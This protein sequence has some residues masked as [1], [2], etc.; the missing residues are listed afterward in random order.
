MNKSKQTIAP[1]GLRR[2]NG[3]QADGEAEQQEGRTTDRGPQ[4]RKRGSGGGSPPVGAWGL[5]PQKIIERTRRSA[6]R[7]QGALM[8]EVAGRDLGGRKSRPATW[9]QEDG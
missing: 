5:S 2:R 4:R 7:E 8:R 9:A 1:Q 3:Q 6:K